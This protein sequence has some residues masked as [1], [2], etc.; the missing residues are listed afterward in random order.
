MS[1]NSRAIAALG[2]VVVIGAGTVG[3]SVAHASSQDK[4]QNRLVTLVAGTGSVHSEPTCWNDGKP[5]DAKAQG[6]CQAKAAKLE[7]D[8]KLPTL[9][10][11][12]SDRVGVGVDPV[13]ADK[14]WF[15]FTDGGTQGQATLASARKGSTFSGAIP[16][17]NVLKS[18]EKTLVTVVEA[19]TRSGDIF[20]VWYFTL[21]NTDI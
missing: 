2:A 14:G 18:T 6:D 13:I 15:A 1:L 5:L 4:P 11:N 7:K 20:G 8:G 10:M 12:T 16:A 21:K 3:F 19:D 17:A 9:E